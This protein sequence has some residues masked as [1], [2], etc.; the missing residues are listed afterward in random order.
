MQ[1]RS[2][3]ARTDARMSLLS[4]PA[5]PSSVERAQLFSR[6][7][8]DDRARYGHDPERWWAAVLRSRRSER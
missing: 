7:D 6:L 1:D 5:Q 3:L 2:P 8:N 4:V